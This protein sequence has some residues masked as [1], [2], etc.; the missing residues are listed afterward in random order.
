MRL[1]NL[2]VTALPI[3]APNEKVT[4]GMLTINGEGVLSI[5]VDD[6]DLTRTIFHALASPDFLGIEIGSVHQL[7]LKED[8]VRE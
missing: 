8:D 1:E 5:V 3:Y 2:E 6:V 7:V 4:R